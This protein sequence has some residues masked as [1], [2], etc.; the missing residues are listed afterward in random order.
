MNKYAQMAKQLDAA[1]KICFTEVSTSAN[2]VL[3]TIRWLY[4][5]RGDS[6]PLSKMMIPN[7]SF[8]GQ[9]LSPIKTIKYGFIK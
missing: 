4:L 9:S 2:L 1:M 5:V 7:I 8:L 3:S 6:P